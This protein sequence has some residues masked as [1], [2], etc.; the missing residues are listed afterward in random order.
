MAITF[1]VLR[2]IQPIFNSLQFCS[3]RS[4]KTAQIIVGTLFFLI[5]VGAQVVIG[6]Y[7]SRIN[8]EYRLRN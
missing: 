4:G 8:T 5:Y 1:V 2:V 3:D 6:L 7:V